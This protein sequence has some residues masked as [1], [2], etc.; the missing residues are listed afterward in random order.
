MQGYSA[1]K[2]LEVCLHPFFLILPLMLS[3]SMHLSLVANYLQDF[4]ASPYK[5]I[6]D[7]LTSSFSKKCFH[8]KG[9]CHE[10]IDFR[11]FS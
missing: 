6:S 5:I 8:L 7:M 1:L 3:G 10:I 4:S 2:N 9:Q 11:F